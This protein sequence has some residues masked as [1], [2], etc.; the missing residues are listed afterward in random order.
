MREHG[1]SYSSDKEYQHRLKVFTENY[2]DIETHN[3]EGH[4]SY[5]RMETNTHM[6]THTVH[7]YIHVYT[8]HTYLVEANHFADLTFQE[9]KVQYLMDPQVSICPSITM[10]LFVHCLT[11]HCS[12]TVSDHKPRLLTDPPASIDWRDKGAITP[13]KNQVIH[14]NIVL[15]NLILSSHNTG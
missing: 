7:T 4:H 2:L 5:E 10:I 14:L 6:H 13:V 9:F 3:K 8:M 11:Q 15:Y 12:A 1:K